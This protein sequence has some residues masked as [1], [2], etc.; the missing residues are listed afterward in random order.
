ME[1][2]E[3][4]TQYIGEVYYL[5]LGPAG[6]ELLEAVIDPLRQGFVLTYSSLKKCVFA[7]HPFCL[8]LQREGERQS[9][10][11]RGPPLGGRNLRGIPGS[12]VPGLP[13]LYSDE[14]PVA[15][16]R[17]RR[18]C[19]DGGRCQ[20]LWWWCRQFPLRVVF[21][22]PLLVCLDLLLPGD[23]LK[24]GISTPLAHSGLSFTTHLHGDGSQSVRWGSPLTPIM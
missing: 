16:R 11:L 17:G 18:R 9:G 2:R 15:S 10:G 7:G 8:I 4:D 19:C 5:L 13:S 24:R 12:F 6:K 3:G 1:L 21:E 22:P 14:S 23:L 20:A